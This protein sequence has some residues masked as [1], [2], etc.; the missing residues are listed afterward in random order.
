MITR[1]GFEVPPAA[2]FDVHLPLMSLPLVMDKFEPI[3]AP[4]IP[5]PPYLRARLPLRAV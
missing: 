5:K 2:E 4:D 1:T 3:S